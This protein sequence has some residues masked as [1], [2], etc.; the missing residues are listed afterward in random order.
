M[1]NEIDWLIEIECHA[2]DDD[3]DH[4]LALQHNQEA[5]APAIR[6]HSHDA[7][8]ALGKDADMTFEMVEG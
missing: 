8:L 1:S 3:I 5:E 4:R 6:A 2:T 7:R